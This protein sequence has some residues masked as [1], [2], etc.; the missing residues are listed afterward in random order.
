V[1]S[2]AGLDDVGKRK[3]L[4]VPGLTLQSLGRSARSD[5]AI[6]APRTFPVVDVSTIIYAKVKFNRGIHCE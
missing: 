4:T 2:R 5:Y 6:P 1:D 3:F